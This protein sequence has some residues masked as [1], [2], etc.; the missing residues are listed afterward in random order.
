MCEGRFSAGRTRPRP[1]LAAGTEGSGYQRWLDL[2]LG[3]SRLGTAR[4]RR[5]RRC[6]RV[7]CTKT[8]PAALSALLEKRHPSGPIYVLTWGAASGHFEPSL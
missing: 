1:G 3:T 8:A 4:D 5:S 6:E 7:V 2:S